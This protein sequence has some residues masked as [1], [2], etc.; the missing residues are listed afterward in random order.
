MTH[1]EPF[2]GH[3][4]IPLPSPYKVVLFIRLHIAYGQRTIYCSRYEFV[5]QG[6]YRVYRWND[7]AQCLHALSLAQIDSSNS[8]VFIIY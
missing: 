1:P 5:A 7:E 4:I 2:W 6:L 8:L 3:V